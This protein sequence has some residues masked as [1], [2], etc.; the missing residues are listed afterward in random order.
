MLC[1]A[2]ESSFVAVFRSSCFQPLWFLPTEK[3]KRS[4]VRG[5]L[6]SSIFSAV[7]IQY[8]LL[9][10]PI[11]A[12]MML[13]RLS[14]ASD[15]TQCSA[16]QA[17]TKNVLRQYQ[18]LLCAESPKGLHFPDTGNTNGYWGLMWVNRCRHYLHAVLLKHY[19]FCWH[20]LFKFFNAHILTHDSRKATGRTV[21]YYSLIMQ[22]LFSN[23]HI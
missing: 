11:L 8:C 22:S 21:N 15:T 17:L 12:V 20:C 3:W 2:L 10:T 19:I 14:L 4:T 6:F 16:Y 18:Q 1:S 5:V 23:H 9:S 7:W 13:R